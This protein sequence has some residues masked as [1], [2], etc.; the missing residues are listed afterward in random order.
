MTNRPSSPAK[1]FRVEEATIDE[2]HQAIKEGWTTCVDV[3]QQYLDRVRAFNGVCST[4]VTEDGSTISEAV[5]T[6][7]HSATEV[8]DKNRQG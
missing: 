5:G 8:P 2:L 4:L 3:V 6:V 1:T 7:R